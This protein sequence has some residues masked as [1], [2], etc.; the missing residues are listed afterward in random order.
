[1]TP[2]LVVVREAGAKKS[3]KVGAESFCEEVSMVQSMPEASK[4]QYTVFI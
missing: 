1:M 4:E 2:F 3:S